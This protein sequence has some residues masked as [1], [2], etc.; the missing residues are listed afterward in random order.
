MSLSFSSLEQRKRFLIAVFV[1]CAVFMIGIRAVSIIKKD[2][3]WHDESISYLVSSCHGSESL[4]NDMARSPV[5]ASEW[6]SLLE[7]TGSYCFDQIRS[8][9]LETDVHP[10]LYFWLL[11]IWS[12]VV[13]IDL[14][15]GP[16]LNVPITLVTLFLLLLLARNV[17]DRP[18]E[19]AVVLVV[20][21]V[22]PYFD[23]I[24]IEARH[25][26]LLTMFS[27][28]FVW[29][30]VRLANKQES[31]RTF[32]YV[33]LIITI[34]LGA[35]THFQFAIVLVA[36]LIVVVTRSY[37]SYRERALLLIGSVCIGY[38][39]ALVLF[40]I[41]NVIGNRQSM[42]SQFSIN[43]AVERVFSSLAAFIPLYS[44][45]FIGIVVFFVA[46]IRKSNAVSINSRSSSRQIDASQIFLIG[47][48]ISGTIVILYLLYLTPRHAMG[49]KYISMAWPFLAFLP[50]LIL[51]YANYR[52]S[53]LLYLLVVGVAVNSAW[54]VDKI[55]HVKA[56]YAQLFEEHEII[57]LN[58]RSQGVVPQV[59][60]HIPDDK[61]VIAYSQSE[62]IATID[63]WTDYRGDN[64]AF[65][66]V[67]S[68]I[69]SAERKREIF[70]RLDELGLNANEIGHLPIRIGQLN[71]IARVYGLSDH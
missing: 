12:H 15:T 33:F 40:P 44:I 34:T 1:V 49:Y 43:G 14:W 50:I 57:L 4:N 48:F 68:A 25:Y 5:A 63:S 8:D 47:L 45:I 20:Y 9:L 61:T 55:S 52:K 41:L 54:L 38:S 39:I 6:K 31:I 27:V 29:Q 69:H 11:H 21:A 3:L 70:D 67:E 64:L 53:I 26:D 66:V 46:K 62:M 58:S 17:L 7:L 60:W 18:L 35:L 19:V 51:R 28:L 65:V 59:V 36:S 24:S 16:L 30:L 23:M 2:T 22:T 42:L 56:D 13:G 32:E 10:P 37:R 71:T